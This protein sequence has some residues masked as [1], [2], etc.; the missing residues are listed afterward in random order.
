MKYMKDREVKNNQKSEFSVFKEGKNL[1]ISCLNIAIDKIPKL[2]RFNL[3]EN[4]SQER[5]DFVLEE[6]QKRIGVEHFHIDL[7]YKDKKKHTGHAR[8]TY[9]DLRELFLK[10]NGKALNHTFD[11]FDAKNAGADIEKIINELINA[12]NL[13]DYK[14]FI[15]EWN[16]IFDKH[17]KNRNEYKEESDLSELG[18]LIEVRTY[19]HKYYVCHKHNATKRIKTYKLP[20][21]KEIA[22]CLS[23]FGDGVDFIII[24]TEGLLD[25]CVGVQYFDKNTNLKEI[26]DYFELNKVPYNCMLN[27]VE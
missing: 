18:F 7:L 20:I 26:Y 6:N 11:L 19:I 5:P 22:D 4:D 25:N 27:V 2:Q 21:T 15:K 14:L 8:Y 1:E 24:V 23:K 12:Q 9:K 10:Y 3:I 17:Y 16:R 13:F